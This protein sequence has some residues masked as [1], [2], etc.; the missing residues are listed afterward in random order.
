MCDKINLGLDFLFAASWSAP[1]FGAEASAS[2]ERAEVDAYF[3][4]FVVFERTGMGLLLRHPDD[5]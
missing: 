5:R 4:R 3:F 1:D 2:A